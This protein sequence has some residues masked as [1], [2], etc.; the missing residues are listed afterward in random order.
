MIF[1]WLLVLLAVAVLASYGPFGEQLHRRV[2]LVSSLA[3][4]AVAAFA[5]R[6]VWGTHVVFGY[7]DMWLGSSTTALTLGMIVV[8]ALFVQIVAYQ[9]LG[10]EHLEGPMSLVRLRHHLAALHGITL[11]A[12]VAAM[13]N[14]LWLAFAG[15][16]VSSAIIFAATG[17]TKKKTALFVVLVL[18]LWAIP[19]GMMVSSGVAFDALNITS[20]LNSFAAQS[21]S[22]VVLRSTWCIALLALGALASFAPFGDLASRITHSSGVLIR[23]MSRSVLAIAATM[24]LLRLA[25]ATTLG[26]ASEVHVSWTL[27]AIGLIGAVWSLVRLY[28][29]R[30]S[31]DVRF[32]MI[33]ALTAFVVGLGPAGLIVA[34]MLLLAR[35]TLAPLTAIIERD[36]VTKRWSRLFS[37]A[38]IGLPL[39]GVFAGLMIMLGY[40]LQLYPALT[41]VMLVIVI[42]WT[43]LQANRMPQQQGDVPRWTYLDTTATSLVVVQVMLTLGLLT[44]YAITYAVSALSQLTNAL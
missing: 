6:D 18:G 23:A 28:Q 21:P 10:Q 39:S 7:A 32:A 19:V 11:A 31:V 1:S 29:G 30:E 4:V 9:R 26:L 16:S 44:P 43:W 12:V 34:L 25:F 15:L 2:S 33:G 42:A 27:L 8:S 17:A 41:L 3:A 20:I 35:M 24:L 14:N 37:L 36:D 22:S 38:S 40:G 13:A 5:I